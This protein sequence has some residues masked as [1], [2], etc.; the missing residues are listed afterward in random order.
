MGQKIG[1]SGSI[2]LLAQ[3]WHQAHAW[4]PAGCSY[5]LYCPFVPGPRTLA[6]M[7]NPASTTDVVDTLGQR[8]LIG[9]AIKLFCIFTPRRPM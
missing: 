7:I 4:L 9:I 3:Y 6:G 2:Q 8:D 5:F 1:Q